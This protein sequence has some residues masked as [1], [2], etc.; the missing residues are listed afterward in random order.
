VTNEIIKK[1][2]L[3]GYITVAKNVPKML[4]LDSTRLSQVIMNLLGNS[5]KFTER[6]Q[7][8]LSLSWI[9]KTE[10]DDSCF[11]PPDEL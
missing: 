10:I 4:K 6:G 11:T 2:G 7:I 1:K 5:S 8:R 3:N 9:N